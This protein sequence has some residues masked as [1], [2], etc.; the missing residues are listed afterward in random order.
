MGERETGLVSGGNSFARL[1]AGRGGLF[2]GYINQRKCTQH[3]TCAIVVEVV[4]VLA[5]SSLIYCFIHARNL[6]HAHRYVHTHTHV[7]RIDCKATLSVA[8]A[9]R[10]GSREQVSERGGRAGG[11][12]VFRDGS[13]VGRLLVF[14][15]IRLKHALY[16]G[17]GRVEGE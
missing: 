15:N 5:L 7:V 2:V 10:N 16:M 11:D 13:K 3:H 14:G 17:G 8:V 12:C 4:E 1:S 6:T 9:I